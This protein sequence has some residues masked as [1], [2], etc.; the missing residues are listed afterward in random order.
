MKSNNESDKSQ[1]QQSQYLFV[2]KG[3]ECSHKIDLEAG[4]EPNISEHG[5]F[6]YP[7]S[8]H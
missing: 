3:E 5:M 1:S 8:V 7:E 6:D 4:Y 2:A